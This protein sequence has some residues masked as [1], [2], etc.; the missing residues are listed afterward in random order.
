MDRLTELSKKYDNNV[1]IRSF[2]NLIPCVGGSLDVILSA[3]WSEFYYRRV[4]NML[5]QLAADL[6]GLNDKID[7]KYLES[8]DFLD[9]VLKVV[10]GSVQTRLDGKR[11]IYS[12]IIRDSITFEKSTLETESLIEIVSNLYE[13]DLILIYKV[14]DFLSNN[15]MEEFTGGD[16]YNFLLVEGMHL[17]INEVVRILY[18]FSYLG[19]L[20][21][22]TTKLTLRHKISFN[23]TPLFD[24]VHG[25]LME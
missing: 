9:I 22:K 4:E 2:F 6:S 18:R 15:G 21:Y 7:N 1:Y 16:L 24:R 5:D 3:K 25:Y 12:K 8:E 10:Q 13:K 14:S 23:K 17:D 19:L 20:D 11:K